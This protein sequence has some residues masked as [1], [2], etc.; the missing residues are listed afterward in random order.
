MVDNPVCTE[1]TQEKRVMV[2][3]SESIRR[4]YTPVSIKQKL[5]VIIMAVSLIG[6]GTVG[7]SIL[8]NEFINLNKM[9]KVDLQVMADIVAETSSGY[10]V[11]ED[12]VG[13]SIFL[14]ALRSKKQI[15]RAILYDKK[16]SIFVVHSRDRDKGAVTYEQINNKRIRNENSHVTKKII[17]DGEVVGYLYMESDDSLIKKFIMDSV[18]GVVFIIILGSFLAY[19]FALKLQ[20][21]ISEP[22]EHLTDTALKITQQQNYALRAEKESEDEIGI[23]TDEFNKM[24]IQLQKRNN[25][26][27]ESENK[28]REVVEQSTD[29]LYVIGSDGEIIDVNNA[30]CVSLGYKRN[31]L[32]C[33]GMSD[34]DAKYNDKEAMEKLLSKLSEKSHVIVESEQIKKNQ[35]VFPVELSLGYLNI[36]GNQLV[37][38]SVRDITERKQAQKNLQLANDLLE[39]KVNERTRELKSINVALEHSKEKAEAASYA[40]SLFLANMSHEIRTPMNAVIG[41]T[42]LLSSSELSGRQEGYV[43]SIQSGSRNLLSL[44]NDILDLS[45]IEAGKMK[46]KLDRVYIKQLME[47]IYQVFQ[48]SAKEKGLTLKLH[49]EDSVPEIIMSDEVRLRQI[50]FNLLNN[51][52]KF[53]RKGEINIYAE[54]KRV[55]ADDMFSSMIIRVEDTGIGVAKED[56]ENIFNIFEQQDNQSTREFGGAGLGLA[57]S[58]R[59]AEKLGA[60]ITVESEMEKGSA[61]QLILH[62]PEIVDEVSLKDTV[63]ISN[64]LIFKPAKVLVVDDIELNRELVCEYLDKQPLTLVIAKDGVEALDLTRSEKPDVVL[65]DIRMPNMNGIEATEIIKNT[66][67]IKEIPVIAITASVVEDKKSEKKRSLFDMVLYKPLNK[68]T[69]I[70]ALSKFIEVQDVKENIDD[71][72]DFTDLF[73]KEISNASNEISDALLEYKQPLEIAKNRGSFGGLDLLLD[74]LQEVAVNFK[75]KGLNHMLDNLKNA[76]QIFDIEEAQKLISKILSGIDKLSENVNDKTI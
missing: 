9:Q 56:Q 20:K 16:K 60:S 18:V 7:A 33:M 75:L 17:F 32:L 61:F 35:N 26:I 55:T 27:I 63:K 41:F 34:I 42:D 29:A 58:T 51:A 53:T 50:L 31:E 71:N 62:S 39:A 13:A 52:I 64:E 73:Y 14:A 45:K 21:I 57:I 43:K 74:E 59:L 44:I 28:F 76:N 22:I 19:F 54:Y 6:L 25:E 2:T 67:A 3:F 66:P 69:L 12:D 24:L 46:I 68:N 49:I 30:A 10:L 1:K 5:M 72:L 40:K 48:I 65:M 70:Q 4:I 37:L 38:A 15:V 36:D 23:L 8:I 11:F 47:D